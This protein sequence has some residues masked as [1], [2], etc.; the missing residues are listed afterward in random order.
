M[1]SRTRT[2]LIVVF[3]IF[4][5]WDLECLRCF[6]HEGKI[7]CWQPSEKWLI[8]SWPTKLVHHSAD[9][10]SSHR[11]KG[12]A[13]LI[14]IMVWLY[15][16]PIPLGRKGAFYLYIWF[17]PAFT[18]SITRWGVSRHPVR[19]LSTSLF[20]SL[21]WSYLVWDQHTFHTVH[22]SDPCPAFFLLIATTS[23]KNF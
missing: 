11:R 19:P 14:S 7:C 10:R 4:S 3:I 6:R 1:E 18:A 12:A 15:R 13:S 23:N 16:K 5:N 21:I 22:V 9:R 17:L 20:E 2:L 8:Y